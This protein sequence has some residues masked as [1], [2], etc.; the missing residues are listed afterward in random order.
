MTQDDLDR[1]IVLI[2]S[3]MTLESPHIFGLQ[4]VLSSKNVGRLESF[5]TAFTKDVTKDFEKNRFQNFRHSKRCNFISFFLAVSEN[6]HMWCIK[7]CCGFKRYS[8]KIAISS[9][10]LGIYV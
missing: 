4:G 5:P 10:C 9:H 3:P 2:Q 1:V 7:F 8:S 6:V